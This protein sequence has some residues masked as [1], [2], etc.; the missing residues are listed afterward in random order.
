MD[1]GAGGGDERAGV[2]RGGGVLHGGVLHKTNDRSFLRMQAQKPNFAE[3]SLATERVSPTYW[4][5]LAPGAAQNSTM[6]PAQ[7][8]QSRVPSTGIISPSRV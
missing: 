3:K 5:S 7:I 2:D 1:G 6:G 4:P 8:V